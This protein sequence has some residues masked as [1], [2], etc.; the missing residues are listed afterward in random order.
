[1]TRGRRY[2]DEIVYDVVLAIFKLRVMIEVSLL[3]NGISDNV[4][5]GF[6]QIIIAYV[7]RMTVST[8]DVGYVLTGDVV[9]GQSFHYS[10]SIP[11]C[12]CIYN[13]LVF[14]SSYQSTTTISAHSTCI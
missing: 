8:N 5:G 11:S 13:D 7:I 12:H 2:F 1:M 3:R 6:E 9:L 10:V 14:T 4:C